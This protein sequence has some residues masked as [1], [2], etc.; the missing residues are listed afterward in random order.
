MPG[1]RRVSKLKLGLQHVPTP[2]GMLKLPSLLV[3]TV[4]SSVVS[5]GCPGHVHV[6]RD[7]PAVNPLSLQTV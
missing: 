7:L 2:A 3:A 6:H 4:G 1:M 5:L